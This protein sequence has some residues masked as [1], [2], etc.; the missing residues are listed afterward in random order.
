MKN[1]IL[2]ITIIL[3]PFIN[4]TSQSDENILGKKIIGKWMMIKVI[5]MSKDVTGKHN[6]EN[7]RWIKFMPDSEETK[8]TFESGKGVDTE[9][10]GKWILNENEL[11]IDSDAGEDDDSYWEITFD[12]DKMFWKGK[13]FE[14][15]KRFE[16]VHERVE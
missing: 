1:I 3:I 11:F 16:I 8:E 6:P 7:N 14:F 4:I 9:N 12:G 5:E 2:I 10:T 15:N 13:R